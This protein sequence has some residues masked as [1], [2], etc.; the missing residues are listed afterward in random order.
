MRVLIVSSYFDGHR[1][2]VEIVA[3]R[4]AQ[5]L[6]RAGATVAWLA[7]ETGHGCATADEDV[8]RAPVPA[9]NGLERIFG[10]PYPIAAPTALAT[11]RREVAEADIVMLH[12]CPV[13]A[14]VATF[15]MA[16]W[17]RKPIMIVQH[18]GTVP[19]RS[20]LLRNA[21]KVMTHLATRPMLAS[22]DQ[23][24]FIS[25]ITAEAFADIR[26]RRPPRLIFNGL[27]TDVFHPARS[28]EERAAARARL[29]LPLDRPVALF[30]GR[31][32][33]KKGLHILRQAAGL[34][35]DTL[36]AFAGWGPLDPRKWGLA[37]VRVY[38]GLAGS[39]LAPLYRASD[40]F[41]LPSTGEGFPLVLQEALA[42][43]LPVVCGED[44]AR[45]DDAFAGMLHTISI[46]RRDPGEVARDVVQ[47]VRAAIADDR[48]D[49]FAAAASR[50]S[51]PRAGGLYLDLMKA[52]AARETATVADV[53]AP[54]LWQP[55]MER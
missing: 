6:R 14:N 13:P 24:V 34:G 50:Y 9:F 27:D 41:V 19:Y 49:Q 44:T 28:R 46:D 35:I 38:E 10:I 7:S 18:I 39:S 51:W 52:L 21:M 55:G 2:G 31:F 26:F 16:R 8:G 37:N 15:L 1:G 54:A 3:G 17:L 5:E 48:R 23:V 42:C 53:A 43:G 29:G 45:A 32:V 20:P 12:D 25:K 4:L 22:A 30:V 36:W 40:A 33:E 47:A 11:I